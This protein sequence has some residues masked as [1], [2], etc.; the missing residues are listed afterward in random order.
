[1]NSIANNSPIIR[2]MVFRI[3]SA[4]EIEN[5]LA[6]HRIDNDIVP[7]VSHKTHSLSRGFQESALKI[8]L[9]IKHEA[10]IQK[11]VLHSQAPHI[12]LEGYGRLGGLIQDNS[13]SSIEYLGENL[14]IRITRLGRIQ[15]TNIILSNE[16]VESILNYISS[17]T[18]I[19]VGNQVFKVAID[20]LLFNAVT[21]KE[22][23]TRFLLKKNFQIS[24]DYA[25]AF[26]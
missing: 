15:N 20:N 14:P 2:E 1:M 6:K 22:V 8:V 21:S 26:K 10:H 16:E 3:I 9:P 18:R 17:R 12:I 4:G 25:E 19:P 7:S 23:G 11:T 13:I 5:T 24:P